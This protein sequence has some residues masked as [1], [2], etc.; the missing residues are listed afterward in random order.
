M[1]F[2]KRLASSI[3]GVIGQ[4]VSRWYS[5]EC[6]SSITALGRW[7]I[8]RLIEAAQKCGNVVYSDTDSVFVASDKESAEKFAA[9]YNSGLPGIM[10][11]RM[12]GYYNRLFIASKKKYALISGRELT[13]RGFEAV[14]SDWCMLAR[15]MQKRILMLVMTGREKDALQAAEKAVLMLRSRKAKNADVETTAT[16]SRPMDKYKSKTP[17]THAAKLLQ[18]K[19]GKIEYGT[20]ISY[21]IA[22]GKGSISD[23]AFPV[24]MMKG[25]KYDAEYYI[26]RHVI[27]AALRVLEALGYTE[28]DIHG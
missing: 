5:Y 23:R 21:I 25:K 22:E 26:N 10:R 28:K 12:Q 14:R 6:A 17:H 4:P 11:L 18:Q 16:I 20:E 3:Y 15:N 13:I 9:E 8:S 7:H 24:S 27:P 1:E 19:G 2:F